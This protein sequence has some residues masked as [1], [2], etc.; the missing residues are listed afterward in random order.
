MGQQFKN[1]AT[2]GLL[3]KLT[4]YDTQ[5]NGCDGVLHIRNYRGMNA[6]VLKQRLAPHLTV[7]KIDVSDKGYHAY[8]K[9]RLEDA[10]SA[11]IKAH[12]VAGANLVPVSGVSLSASR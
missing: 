10:Q 7:E 9:G 2:I 5:V 3:N 8:Y 4:H 11:V 6:E 1:K 12:L